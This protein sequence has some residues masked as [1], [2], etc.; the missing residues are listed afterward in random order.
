MDMYLFAPQLLNYSIFLFFSS[1]IYRHPKC[2][3]HI[4]GLTSQIPVS[5]LL[6][7][8]AQTINQNNRHIH[9]DGP[10]SICG[11]KNVQGT[12]KSNTG[13]TTEKIQSVLGRK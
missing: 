4:M 3:L 13:Q 6:V 7:G 8:G 9:K 1:V 5:Q 11:Q 10:L 2:D 12:E